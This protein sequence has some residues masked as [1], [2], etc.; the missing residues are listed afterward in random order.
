MSCG[1]ISYSLLNK[2]YILTKVAM[3]MEKYLEN[4]FFFQ[5]RESQGILLM[6]REI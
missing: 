6:A 1:N 5:V 3:I 4:G 2:T